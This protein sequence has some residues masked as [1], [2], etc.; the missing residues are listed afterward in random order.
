M[1]NPPPLRSAQAV[2][3]IR[4][5]ASVI[6]SARRDS[7]EPATVVFHEQGIGHRYSQITGSVAQVQHHQV[8]IRPCLLAVIRTRM[9]AGDRARAHAA[10]DVIAPAA[11]G[12]RACKR[13]P[14]TQFVTPIFP[15]A[16]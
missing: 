4:S 13:T 7:N 5:Q 6:L 16:G 8:S 15:C 3:C 10:E 1:I 2:A 11:L 14:A 12:E 9:R